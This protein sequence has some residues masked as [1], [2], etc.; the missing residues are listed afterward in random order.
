MKKIKNSDLLVYT[1]PTTF[2]EKL[3]TDV[4]H[5]LPLPPIVMQTAT[6]NE[7]PVGKITN[8]FLLDRTFV[9]FLV[10]NSDAKTESIANAIIHNRNTFNVI[11]IF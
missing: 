4:S 3:S 5:K 8:R 6:E 11:L 9:S 2:S 1:I 7:D 10:C